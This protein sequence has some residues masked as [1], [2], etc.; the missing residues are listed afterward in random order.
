MRINAVT[1]IQALR[2][3]RAM[4]HSAL[5]KSAP[6]PL[7]EPLTP[8]PPLSDAQLSEQ[9]RV[10][11]A[12]RLLADAPPDRLARALADA[13]RQ[14]VVKALFRLSG[15]DPQLEKILR[16]IPTESPAATRP[17]PGGR[18]TQ[19]QPSQPP[20][21]PNASPSEIPNPK[22][23]ID[24]TLVTLAREVA[25]RLAAVQTGAGASRG[26]LVRPELLPA[27]A[28]LRVVLAEPPILREGTP[29]APPADAQSADPARR[30]AAPPAIAPEADLPITE[31]RTQ[32]RHLPLDA[33]AA[34][35][36]RSPQ[37]AIPPAA[38][39]R[40]SP[41]LIPILAGSVVAEI[42]TVPLTVPES[43]APSRELQNAAATLQP[44][45]EKAAPKSPPA[46]PTALLR[47]LI[48]RLA[49]FATPAGRRQLADLQASSNRTAP[50]SRTT[51]AQPSVGTAGEISS[52]L[53][54]KSSVEP[55]PTAGGPPLPVRVAAGAAPPRPVPIPAQS[56]P[57][58]DAPLN[59]PRNTPTPQ[60]AP[61]LRASLPP[62]PS[63]ILPDWVG[64]K[65]SGFRLQASGLQARKTLSGTPGPK[66]EAAPS[67]QTHRFAIE[68]RP[69]PQL[70]AAVAR[71]AREGLSVEW[72][73]LP[74][75]A[76]QPPL[77]LVTVRVPVEGNAEPA[78]ADQPS[79]PARPSAASP[80]PAPD[81]RADRAEPQPPSHSRN[82]E[83]QNPRADI[84][85]LP[86][87]PA[88]AE[89]PLARLA[90]DRAADPLPALPLAADAPRHAVVERYDIPIPVAASQPNNRR[91]GIRDSKIHTAPDDRNEAFSAAES[92]PRD[93]ALELRPPAGLPVLLSDFA[94]WI[95]GRPTPDLK[96]I[97][98][99]ALPEPD[100]VMV[101]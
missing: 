20:K 26:S 84:A 85:P 99:A 8:A 3:A 34:L 73:F 56:S 10:H 78:R 61:E 13:A 100:P 79:L 80:Q 66:S 98:P 71:L 24:H 42:P 57:L 77:A 18:I 17:G 44:N 101:D 48:D 50:L 14:G 36:P 49:P 41:T 11:A 52:P 19:P 27:A 25:R 1:D 38:T 82:S 76:N 43:A 30:R 59:V 86:H 23:E 47:E 5:V 37:T 87:D 97:A 62:Q 64:E 54:A 91:S 83:I 28:V 81:P 74:A 51:P 89:N 65:A 21:A 40:A 96:R 88:R 6:L 16:L 32:P 92:I 63:P 22:S 4:L 69:G 2:E 53:D 33:R 93:R 94:R 68:V 95:A 72:E 31:L 12:L 67:A 60:S 58:G 9:A 90:T 15:A 46:D 39:T 35:F 70:R 45:P 75:R 29:V 7:A 55:R